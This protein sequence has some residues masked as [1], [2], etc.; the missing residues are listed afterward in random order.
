MNTELNELGNILLAVTQSISNREWAVIIWISLF[1]LCQMKRKTFR[2]CM[3]QILNLLSNK[4]IALPLLFCYGY[5]ITYVYFAHKTGFAHFYNA[6]DFIFWCLLVPIPSMMS[7]INGDKTDFIKFAL[8]NG[9]LVSLILA[10]QSYYTFNL[11]IEFI[12][13]PI[14]CF[15]AALSAYAQTDK[16]YD[17]IHK[18][19]DKSMYLIGLLVLLYSLYHAVSDINELIENHFLYSF[20]FNESLYIIYTPLLYLYCV[21]AAYEYWFTCIKFRSSK[22]NYK[23]RCIFFIKKCGLNLSKI[24]YISKHLHVYVPQT[25][26]QLKIDFMECKNKHHCK[27]E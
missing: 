13:F 6:K 9:T 10:L 27:N 14:L 22:E 8:S 23:K 26:E 18:F 11:L 7:Y 3:I 2:S 1:V 20:I 17:S 15:A 24:R 5:M 12:S 16:K 19:I 25:E 4:K 21:A